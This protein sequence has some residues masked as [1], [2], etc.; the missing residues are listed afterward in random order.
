MEHEVGRTCVELARLN[1]ISGNIS[2]GQSYLERAQSVF[3]R[4]GATGDYNKAE[5]IKQKSQ[6]INE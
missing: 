3:E 5:E 2:E 4:L 1:F 6:Y